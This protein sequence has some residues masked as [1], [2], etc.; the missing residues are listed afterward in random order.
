MSDILN[1]NNEIKP[2]L[3]DVFDSAPIVDDTV[4]SETIT[5]INLKMKLQIL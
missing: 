4:I 5:T 2:A 1:Q 3:T